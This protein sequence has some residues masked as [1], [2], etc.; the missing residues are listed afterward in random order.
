MDNQKAPIV[1]AKKT[2]KEI[3]GIDTAPKGK[4]YLENN[5]KSALPAFPIDLTIKQTASRLVMFQIP[6]LAKQKCFTEDWCIVKCKEFASIQS[7]Y[8]DYINKIDKITAELHRPD[9][10][11]KKVLELGWLKRDNS[12]Q[13]KP[14]IQYPDTA[15][16]SRTEALAAAEKEKESQKA[17][18]PPAKDKYI[19]KTVRGRETKILDENC[20]NLKGRRSIMKAPLVDFMKDNNHVVLETNYQKN[21]SSSTW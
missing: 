9:N 15:K 4:V 19:T 16:T 8:S 14:I 18:F 5:D 13:D 12:D 20:V 10:K 17:T 2:K 1:I 6:D 21:F 11:L 7:I 3:P